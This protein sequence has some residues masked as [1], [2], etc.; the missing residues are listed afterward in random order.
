MKPSVITDELSSDFDTAL[1]L[2]VELGFE[3]VEIRGVGEGRF[4]RVTDLMR[5]AVPELCRE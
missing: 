2:A 5:V 1:E 3:G 4:P